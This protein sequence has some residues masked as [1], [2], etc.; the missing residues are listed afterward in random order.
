MS[1]NLTCTSSDGDKFTIDEKSAQ[2]SGL[3][4]GLFE[5]YKDDMEDTPMAD[6][7]SLILKKVFE[8]LEHYK[9]SD[10]KEIPRPL[11]SADMATVCSEWDI[12]F[13]SDLELDSVFDVIN[14][15]NY[16]D[17]KPLL[18]LTCAKI[19]SEMKGKT[20]DEIRT[21]FNIENDLTEEEMKEYEEYQI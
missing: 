20:A 5:D 18:D 10:P 11:P 4:K 9:E 16:L 12:K 1:R 6:I 13:L 7:S 3:L 17:V 19:A 2:R 21:K 15:A 8:Y 14:A